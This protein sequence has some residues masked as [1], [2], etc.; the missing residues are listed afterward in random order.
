MTVVFAETVHDAAFVDVRAIVSGAG[1]SGR[2][3]ANKT[4]DF[5]DAN[6]LA[7]AVRHVAF[8]DVNTS[9]II[10][11]IHVETGTAT[12]CKSRRIDA[13]LIAIRLICQAFVDVVALVPV[14]RSRSPR[15]HRDTRI[16]R[17]FVNA[18]VSAASVAEEA[19]ALVDALAWIA[20]IGEE[21]VGAAALVRAV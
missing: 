8:I 7:A 10:S 2:T 11:R 14:N 15:N 16:T 3:G 13:N 21:F 4:A 12:A 6:L 17:L 9:F 5:V 19:L 18:R 20:R 1:E